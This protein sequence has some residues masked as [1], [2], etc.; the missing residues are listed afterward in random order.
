M[1]VMM[2]F[3][4]STGP[5]LVVFE[6]RYGTCA[7]IAGHIEKRLRARGHVVDL[8]STPGARPLSL[9]EYS[10]VIVIAAVYNQ[11]HPESIERFVRQHTQSL[12]WR[13]TAFISVSLGAAARLRFIRKS[14]RRIAERFFEATG[15]RPSRVLYTGGTLDYPVYSPAMLRWTRTAAFVFGLPTDTT[16]RHELT[17]WDDID[18]VVDAVLDEVDLTRALHSHALFA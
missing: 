14:I 6:T 1:D 11:H 9:D 13:P 2:P 18:A 8:E 10:A 4:E 12:S 17:R 7:K 3:A 5:I 15:W 16:R